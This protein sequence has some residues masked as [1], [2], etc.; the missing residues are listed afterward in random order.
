MSTAGAQRQLRLD[1]YHAGVRLGTLVWWL[2]SAAALFGAGLWVGGLVLGAASNWL[3]LPWLLISLL[4]SQALGQAGERWLMQHW[5]SG[6]SLTLEGGRLVL[7]EPAGAQTFDLGLKL[8]YWR[9]G[10]TVKQRRG[11]RVPNGHFCYALRLVQS[12][13][14]EASACVYAFLPPGPAAALR[15][16]FPCYE[17]RPADEPATPANGAAGRDPGFLAVEKLRWDSGAELEPA[18]LQLLLEHLA[19]HGPDFKAHIS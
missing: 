6:R 7:R 3:W 10:F 13:G 11:G 1:V 16:R 9:W 4:L 8:N 17:L 15:E 5:P 12:A 14:P 19:S 18:D 2:G